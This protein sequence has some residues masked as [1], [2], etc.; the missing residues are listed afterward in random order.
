MIFLPTR[1]ESEGR[2]VP[3]SW[4]VWVQLKVLKYVLNTGKKNKQNQGKCHIKIKSVFKVDFQW[5]TYSI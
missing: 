2:T 4:V 5:S 1:G 3:S